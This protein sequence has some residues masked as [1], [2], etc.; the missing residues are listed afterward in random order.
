MGPISWSVTF[1][2][3]YLKGK[4][5]CTIDLLFD[6]FGLVCFANKNKNCQLLYSWFKTSQTGGQWYSYTSL[7]SIPCITLGWGDSPRKTLQLMAPIGNLWM[8]DFGFYKV[9]ISNFK[10]DC[11]S[12]TTLSIITRSMMTL[13][14][15]TLDK[16]ANNHN[17][18][19]NNNKHN[20]NNPDNN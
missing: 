18:N 17:D 4:Y 3:E 12:V 19:H 6:L 10:L 7:C 15:M 8:I 11:F 1:L 9:R 14:L 13:I 16:N 5:H 20:L 2:R